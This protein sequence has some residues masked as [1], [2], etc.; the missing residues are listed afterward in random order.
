MRVRA[1]AAVLV[2]RSVFER[3]L[4]PTGGAITLE[5]NSSIIVQVHLAV[6]LLPY[7][8]VHSFCSALIQS[9]IACDRC[10]AFDVFETI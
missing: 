10:C 6:L 5:T 8:F 9:A 2:E 1:G 4:G 7:A 3:N